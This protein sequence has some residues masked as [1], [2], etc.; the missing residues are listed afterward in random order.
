MSGFLFQAT[1]YTLPKI[2]HW[3]NRYSNIHQVGCNAHALSSYHKEKIQKKNPENLET[4]F[5]GVEREK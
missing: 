1:E 5:K 2:I 4:N 3:K